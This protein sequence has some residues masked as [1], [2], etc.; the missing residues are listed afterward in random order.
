MYIYIY[1]Y[2]YTYNMCDGTTRD[3]CLGVL[4]KYPSSM[5]CGPEIKTKSLSPKGGPNKKYETHVSSDF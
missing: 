2:I 3:G 5:A 1:I 4:F